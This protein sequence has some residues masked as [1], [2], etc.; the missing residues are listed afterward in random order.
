MFFSSPEN[1]NPPSS[2][3]PSAFEQALLQVNERDGFSD[4]VTF[5]AEQAGCEFLFEV[6]GTLFDQDGGRAAVIR[7]CIDQR[8][9]G[10]KPNCILYIIFDGED[11]VIRILEEFEAPGSVQAMTHSYS[12]VLEFLSGMAISSGRALN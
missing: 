10:E 11:G 6:P 7:S 9:D 4:A 8:E 3:L 5:A 12:R 2:F 1:K